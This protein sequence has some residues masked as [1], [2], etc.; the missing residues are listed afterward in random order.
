M[1]ATSAFRDWLVIALQLVS[2][3]AV[4]FSAIKIVNR[5]EREWSQREERM[6]RMESELVRVMGDAS[7][8]VAVEA[9]LGD[10]AS[11]MARV[12]DR[13]DRFLDTYPAAAR[14]LG[15]AMGPI[16]PGAGC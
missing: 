7:R 10:I 9:K 14:G 16:G 2:L 12:R 4:V 3:F 11:E 6:N 13:L 1:S 8:L 5:N 15:G